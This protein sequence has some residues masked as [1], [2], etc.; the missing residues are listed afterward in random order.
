MS[1]R[2]HS[3]RIAETVQPHWPLHSVAAAALLTLGTYL[4]LPGMEMFSKSPD[5]ALLVR[6]FDVAEPP[7]VPTR[8]PPPVREERTV[9]QEMPKPHL[10][11]PRPTPVPLSL[12]MNLDLMLGSVGGDFDLHFAETASGALAR[13]DDGVFELFELD[14]P[15][16]ALVKFQPLYPAQARMRQIEG[17]VVLEFVV[18]SEG[19]PRDIEVVS[20]TP[21]Q[22][23]AE[24]AVRAVNR[25][26]FSPGTREGRP[27][28]VRVR[29]KIT[30][31]LED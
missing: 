16:Q 2:V 27:V 12:A 23:F 8:P 3:P 30:F 17:T 31:R 5:K 18:G 10:T 15:P 28:P 6:S 20:S 22:V 14:E 19:R 11:P 21:G 25:W 1:Q 13:I 26:R 4:I 29:Q 24:A 7:P 9:A